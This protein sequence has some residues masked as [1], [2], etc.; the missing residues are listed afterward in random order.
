MMA[1]A[2]PDGGLLLTIKD[3]PFDNPVLA[4]FASDGALKMLAYLVLLYDP[5]PPAF[6]GIEE[7]ENFLH[8]RLARRLGR[9][10]P[11]SFRPRTVTGDNLFTIFHQSTASRI[12]AGALPRRCWL[13][14]NPTSRVGPLMALENAR[15]C[16]VSEPAFDFVVL[17]ELGVRFAVA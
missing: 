11:R 7:P 5:A 3:A 6:I 15:K 17:N 13:H 10:V 8:P 1:D 14:P 12:S 4:R 9:G 2:M 16:W